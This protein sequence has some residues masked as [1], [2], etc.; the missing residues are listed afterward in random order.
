MI[1]RPHCVMR[2][3]TIFALWAGLCVAQETTP[4]PAPPPVP[5]ASASELV[6]YGN[7]LLIDGKPSDALGAY[8]Q[9]EELEPDAREIAFVEG[10]GHYQLGQ[11][12]QAREA[13]R[14]AAGTKIDGLAD[15]ALYSAATCDH[16]EALAAGDDPKV[17]IA[18]LENAMQTYHSVL[19]RNPDHQAA[20]DA[21][22]K[23]ASMWRQ[24]KRRLEQQQQQKQSDQEGDD[25]ENEEEQERQQS[26]SDK[27]S[28]D[29]Q[30]KDSSQEQE[31]QDQ[32]QQSNA[33]EQQEQ[34]PKEHQAKEQEERV[35]REQA[36]RKLR[37]MMQAMRDRKKARREE[38][39]RI[40]V[41]RTIKD[42]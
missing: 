27:S 35:S 40:P 8:H 15:D 9:A 5:T 34:S 12:D 4:V 41:S 30:Q 1:Y 22:F 39:Q 14:Q 19:E 31:D 42:W 24:L 28:D 36:E 10:L 33:N 37:E 3:L 20:R 13:F 23:A 32:Q 7:R 6:R 29:Q 18:Q 11:Y 21:N 25:K 16:A 26:D 2:T 17:A 38:V